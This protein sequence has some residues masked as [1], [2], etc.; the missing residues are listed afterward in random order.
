MTSRLLES[1]DT[2]WQAPAAIAGVAALTAWVVWIYQRDAAELSGALRILLVILRLAAVAAVVVA[3][4]DIERIAEHE[5]VLPS[6][7]AVLIDASGSMSLPEEAAAAMTRGQRAIDVLDAGGLLAAL[8]SR[9]EVSIWRFDAD[10]EPLVVLPRAGARDDT[11]TRS[12]ADEPLS[13][14]APVDGAADTE[15]SPGH[16]P[17]W[18]EA[19]VPRGYETRLGEAIQSVAEREPAGVLAGVVVLTD[20]GNNAGIDPLAAVSRLAKGAVAVTPLGFGSDVLPANLRVAD[21]LVPPRVFPGDAFAVTAYLQAQGLAGQR[22]QVDLLEQPE[23]LAGEGATTGRVID[24]LEAIIAA[25]GELVAVRFDVS[26]LPTPGSR[27]LAVR[28]A[29]PTADGN[30]DDDIQAASVEVVDRITRVL[31]MAGGP[32]REYQFMRNVL[33]RDAS[34]EV[35]VLLGTAAPGMSQD[36]RR[37]L[38]AFP[39]SDEALADYDAVVAIDYDWRLVEPAGWARLERWVAQES[40]GLLVFAGGISM[41]GW[42][43]DPRS[44]PL[45]GLYP[46]EL[47]RPGQLSLGGAVGEEEPMPLEITPDGVDAEFLWLAAGRGASRGVWEEF[48]GI[49]ACFPTDDAKAGATVYARV[50]RPGAAASEPRRVFLAGQPYGSGS[51]LYAGSSELWRLRLLDDAAYERLVPQLLRHVSQGRLM[52]GTRRARLLV[53]RDRH[54]VG[55]SVQVRL[56]LSDEKMLAAA[57]ARPPACR[58]VGPAG[59]VVP[60]ALSAETGR[61]GVLAGG[62][63]PGREGAWRIE[64]DPAAGLGDETIV[65]RIQVQLPDRE[66]ARPK[67]DRPLLEQLATRTGSTPRF[68]SDGGWSVAEAELLARS[69]PDRSRREYKAGAADMDFKQRLNAVLLA[70]GCGFLCLEWILRRIVRLA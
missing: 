68:L 20:G 13:E 28:V 18:R 32:G 62:F 43:S 2:W 64:V 37:I 12:V 21:L 38:D 70:T 54:P 67:L 65:K 17:D 10:A 46:V 34:F 50:A 15:P 25:D 36:A 55:G 23:G 42:L 40:G 41:D 11:T 4:L 33:H 26:G 30:A 44:S 14:K 63:V 69:F 19:V 27:S 56:A 16:A 1:F 6:R 49:Y 8:T 66:L 59:S 52:R 60:I 24:T 31:L 47:R 7:V 45:R 39:P 22:V 48:P 58:A 29:A 3:C 53:D 51:V 57:A 5:I 61:P 35:D 9:H